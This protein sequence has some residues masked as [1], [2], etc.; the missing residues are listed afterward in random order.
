VSHPL[1]LGTAGHID[2]GKTSLVYAL[3]GIDTDRLPVEKQRGITTE[4]G[5]AH[6]EL[7]GQRVAMVDVPGHERFV[8]AMVAGAGGVDVVCMVIAADEGVMPQ[9]R[10]HLDI[11]DLLGVR[12]GVVALTKADLVD[13]E[14]LAMVSAELRTTLAGGFLADAPIV[15][16]SARTGA[17]LDALRAALADIVRTLPPRDATGVFRLPIDRVFTVRGFGTVVTGTISSGQIAVGDEIVVLP[18]G[19]AGRV[20]GLEVHGQAA[21]RAPAGTRAA[22]NLGG[23]DADEVA[24]GDVVTRPGQLVPSHILDVR[25][26]YLRAAR[27][28]LPR[29]SKVLLHHGTTQVEARLV[30]ADRDQLEPGQTA[31][32]QLRIDATTPLAALPGDRF[33]AR[34]FAPLADYGT[35]LGGGDI[36]RVLAAKARH[37]DHAAGVARLADA[38]ARDRLVDDV[39]MAAGAGRT[40]ADAVVRTG[41]GADALRATLA[42]L[43]RSGELLVVG[44]GDGAVYLHAATVASLEQQIGAQLAAAAAAGRSSAPREEVRARLPAALPA[45]AFDLIVEGMATRGL[46][47]AQA[48][49]LERPPPAAAPAPAIDPLEQKV[50][51]AYVRWGVTAPRPLDV[52][53]E[54]AAPAP[55]VKATLDRLLAGKVLV[56]IKPDY[57]L[58]AAVVADLRARLLAHLATHGQITP[59]EWKDLTGA[60]RKHSIPLAEYFDGEKVTLRVGDIRRKR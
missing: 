49:T 43:A 52:P 56:K 23:L 48:D 19:R 3:T 50:R 39:R 1:V 25:F 28:A 10:E 21:E 44:D 33:I 40:L 7:A 27:T 31:V 18:D 5:F 12:R 13:D 59:G 46:V 26:R 36:V 22:L 47:V 15:P 42:A 34:G 38:S 16:V 2:H 58:D 37:G 24:R 55:A 41:Q 11:C 4:L 35:T 20:R 14:W 17:G 29:R 30:L 8:K 45:R 6:L 57:F 53:T 9:T 32:A 51:A 60:T 54:L